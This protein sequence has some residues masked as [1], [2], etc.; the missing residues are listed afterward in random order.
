[1][2]AGSTSLRFHLNNHP[3]IHLPAQELNFFNN[4]QNFNKGFDWYSKAVLKGKNPEAKIFGEKSPAYGQ[5]DFAPAK[6]ATHFP[7]MKIIWV[8]RDPVDRA[9]SNYLHELKMGW[10]NLSFK[11]ALKTEQKRA[12]KDIRY[13]YLA[14]S[15]YAD[16]LANYLEHF[17]MKQ[18][19]VLF[20]DELIRP[21]DQQHIL[22]ELFAFLGT[23]AEG[24]SFNQEYR[25]KTVLPKY[26]NLL[27]YSNKLGLTR[28]WKLNKVIQK[29]NFEG[30]QSGYPKLDSELRA[31]LEAHFKGP[32][33][34]LK[35]LLGREL[36]WNYSE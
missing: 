32:N 16:Q 5:E 11:Q 35:E 36:P 14:H 25:N 17:P 26:P 22:H 18:Q 30:Q 8:L 12:T 29:L 7:Q 23:D 3:K 6:I 1:M 10:E 34:R 33:E 20:L 21:F 4:S 15:N 13:G 27:Y 31:E 24:F 28:S 2:K 19:F 9:Y